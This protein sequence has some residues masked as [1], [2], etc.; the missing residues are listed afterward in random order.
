MSIKKVYAIGTSGFTTYAIHTEER[1][2]WRLESC[3]V[4]TKAEYQKARKDGMPSWGEWQ[5][6]MRMEDSIYNRKNKRRK[7]ACPT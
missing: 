6:K 4:V 7:E 1:Y 3:R 2:L 5:T